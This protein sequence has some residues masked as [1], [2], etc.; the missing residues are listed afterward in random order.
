MH[1]CGTRRTPLFCGGYR[2]VSPVGA[3]R[4]GLDGQGSVSACVPPTLFKTDALSFPISEWGGCIVKNF[5]R[6]QRDAVAEVIWALRR[7]RYPEHGGAR[8]AA[9]DFGVSPTQWSQWETGKRMPGRLRLRQLA[10]FFG[11]TPQTFLG[12]AAAPASP[13]P[14]APVSPSPLPAVPGTSFPEL[15][16]TLQGQRLKAIYRVEVTVSDVIYEKL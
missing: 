14:G 9:G 13:V 8:R 16:T 2:H 3:G 12:D 15:L 5:T 1:Y 6:E 4:G 11:V 10:Q 7:S